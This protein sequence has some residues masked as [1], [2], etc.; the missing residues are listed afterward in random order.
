VN[1]KEREQWDNFLEKYEYYKGIS[2]YKNAVVI[3]PIALKGNEYV[4]ERLLR[5]PQ[6]YLR[7]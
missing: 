2:P 1:D 6:R 4:Y 3:H 5:C 7:D